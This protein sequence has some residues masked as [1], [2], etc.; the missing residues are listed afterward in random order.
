VCIDLKDTRGAALAAAPAA[1][2]D[3]VIENHRPGVLERLGPG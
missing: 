1:R 2:A 3:V